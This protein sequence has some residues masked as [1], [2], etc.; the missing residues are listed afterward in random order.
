M[1][2][3]QRFPTQFHRACEK[4]L[5][6]VRRQDRPVKRMAFQARNLL[7]VSFGARGALEELADHQLLVLAVPKRIELKSTSFN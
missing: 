7:K 1:K 5:V 6:S 3:A 4:Q 2:R